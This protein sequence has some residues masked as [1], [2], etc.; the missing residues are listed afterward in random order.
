M[1]AFDASKAYVDYLA[2]RGEKLTVNQALSMKISIPLWQ[3]LPLMGTLASEIRNL[4]RANKKSDAKKAIKNPN[5]LFYSLTIRRR[6]YTIL[7]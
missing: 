2:Q 5:Y 1:S 3:G 7:F 6:Y 4:L